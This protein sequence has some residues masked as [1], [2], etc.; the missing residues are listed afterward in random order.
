MVLF[1]RWRNEVSVFGS[2]LSLFSRIFA[3][4]SSLFVSEIRTVTA[5]HEISLQ[6]TLQT[7]NFFARSTT[8]IAR[9]F[10]SCFLASLLIVRVS[11]HLW[12]SI[13]LSKTVWACVWLIFEIG[14]CISFLFIGL[15]SFKVSPRLKVTNMHNFD[16]GIA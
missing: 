10:T 1:I 3:V 16:C 13:S 6:G 2:H 12:L 5:S 11:I 14:V 4:F 15:V 8:P 7:I 9:S